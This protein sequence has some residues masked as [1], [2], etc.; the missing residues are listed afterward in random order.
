VKHRLSA[1]KTHLVTPKVWPAAWPVTLDDLSAAGLAERNPATG[2]MDGDL[3]IKPRSF[4]THYAFAGT[5]GILLQ[6]PGGAP[7]AIF[8]EWYDRADMSAG[9]PLLSRRD[10][11]YC[12]VWWE[13]SS[14]SSQ[15]LSLGIL[16]AGALSYVNPIEIVY[17]Q[18]FFDF[19]SVATGL[20][21]GFG[22]VNRGDFFYNK[23]KVRVRRLSDTQKEITVTIWRSDILGFTSRTLVMDNGAGH[24]VPNV[25]NALPVFVI[26]DLGGFYNLYSAPPTQWVKVRRFEVSLTDINLQ[27]DPCPNV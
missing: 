18:I 16:P 9:D 25:G 11:C 13:S 22:M 20:A 6:T 15:P 10:D 8:G 23:M 2:F 5:D 12:A 1:A 7:G 21:Y 14:T 26:C 24:L 4:A 17:G 3:S 19:T 27:G